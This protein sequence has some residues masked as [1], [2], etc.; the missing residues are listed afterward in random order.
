M[1]K[2]KLNIDGSEVY[3]L[4]VVKGLVSEGDRLKEDIERLKPDFDVG[5]LPISKEE[6]KGLKDF[7][8][9]SGA[10]DEIEVEPSTPERI[11]A[12]KLSQFG[13]V[14][15]PPPSYTF[16]LDYCK[17]RDIDIEAF[18]MD[19]EHYT[20][21]YCDHVTGTQ[22][23]RQALRE[24]TL[25]RKNVDAETPEEFA[26]KWDK[27]I[28]K[29]T[30]FQELENHREKVMAKNIKRLSKRGALI[31]LIEEERMEGVVDIL[32]ETLEKEL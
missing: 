11:Y 7:V 27:I 18:D 2:Y 31:G 4:G 20:M 25:R 24:K 10:D 13:E 26:L 3:L 19:E 5:G 17:E 22:W 9:K 21:A 14:S 15:L 30:G 29:L 1:S 28:N 23:L 32:S 6:V 12:E 16:F 8:E